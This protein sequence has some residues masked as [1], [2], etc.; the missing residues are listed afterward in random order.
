MDKNRI[1][2]GIMED[3]GVSANNGFDTEKIYLQAESTFNDYMKHYQKVNP[4]LQ[5]FENRE[6]VIEDTKA[7]LIDEF[8]KGEN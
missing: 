7:S 5:E 2:L 4:N 6:F 8:L 1:V 3:L